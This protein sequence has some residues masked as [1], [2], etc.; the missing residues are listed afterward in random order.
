GGGRDIPFERY[1]GLQVHDRGGTAWFKSR[2]T[3][4]REIGLSLRA[5]TWHVLNESNRYFNRDSLVLYVLE[6]KADGSVQSHPYGFT[7]PRAERIGLNLG[8]ILA[9]CAI[10]P[11]EL[12]R[13]EL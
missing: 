5:V 6:R 3:P 1:D 12:A 8:W 9:N 4:A 2:E 7:E 11:R 13:P 10:T